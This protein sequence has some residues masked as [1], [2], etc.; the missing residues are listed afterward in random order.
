LQP[1]E[2]E[3]F[4][5]RAGEAATRLFAAQG[6]EA[7][8]LRAVAAELGVSAMTPYR[9]IAGK[10]ELI[11]LVRTRAFQQFA[12]ELERTAG[13]VA[14]PVRRL[15]VLKQ[16]YL[17]FAV[18]RADEYRIM[19][20]LRGARDDERWPELT[21]EATRAFGALLD[22]VR[23]AIAT[24]AIA[25]DAMVVAQLLWAGAHGLASLR[26][27]GRITPARFDRLAAIDH[28]LEGFRTKRRR[29]T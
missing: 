29:K 7:V 25:G 23:A 10:D 28:E 17:A 14:D 18:E 16:A 24:K 9:Y 19:F 8:T 6:Y 13:R 27:A 22:A 11:A 26:L 15:R 1:D 21:R 12:D 2:V 20:E 4:R 3:A 5:R